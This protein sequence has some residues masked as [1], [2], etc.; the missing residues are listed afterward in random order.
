MLVSLLILTT[1]LLAVLL[2]IAVLLALILL[3]AALVV[4]ALLTRLLIAGL[5]LTT[6]LLTVLLAAL[7]LLLIAL[8]LLLLLFVRHNR[9]SS[10]FYADVQSKRPTRPSCPAFNKNRRAQQGFRHGCVC[11]SSYSCPLTN[12]RTERERRFPSPVTR[13]QYCSK[14][15]LGSARIIA[16]T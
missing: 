16:E 4:L 9:S 5:V 14:R 15:I 10:L 2:L 6:T 7:L 11:M 3:A 13:L 8:L 12:I 1:L